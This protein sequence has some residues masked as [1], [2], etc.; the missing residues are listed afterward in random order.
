M[1]ESYLKQGKSLFLP[2]QLFKTTTHYS[3]NLSCLGNMVFKSYFPVRFL[4]GSFMTFPLE[5]IWS[6]MGKIDMRQWPCHDHFP[7]NIQIHWV[8]LS[9]DEIN[10]C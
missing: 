10:V 5:T 2:Q 8:F 9:S 6:Q 3:R 4:K 7:N 1:S